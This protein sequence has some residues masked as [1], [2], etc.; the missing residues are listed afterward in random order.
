MSDRTRQLLIDD[1]NE[2][3]IGHKILGHRLPIDYSE[4]SVTTQLI[5]QWLL[6]DNLLMSFISI[7]YVW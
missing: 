1:I 6:I 2:Q 4:K 3:S 5:T 7:S